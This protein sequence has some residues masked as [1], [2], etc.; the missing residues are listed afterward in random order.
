LAIY[1]RISC[2]DDDVVSWIVIDDCAS[3]WI[4]I[5]HAEYHDDCE[6]RRRACV[7][8]TWT[9]PRPSV[10]SFSSWTIVYSHLNL[11]V[12]RRC[13]HR[14]WIDHR[15]DQLCQRYFWNGTFKDIV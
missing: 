3:L 9:L 11:I 14:H 7:S 6:H 8:V 15:V 10:I 2:H 5:D 1:W 13:D 12:Q 4:S